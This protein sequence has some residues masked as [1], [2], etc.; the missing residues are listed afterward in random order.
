M[1]T[2]EY[3][4]RYEDNLRRIKQLRLFDD[5]SFTKCFEGGLECME[6]LLHVILEKPDLRVVE[7]RVQYTIKN[8]QGR[9]VRR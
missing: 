7:V 9:S 3:N 2:E 8:L 6:L 1:D 5:D 4:Q